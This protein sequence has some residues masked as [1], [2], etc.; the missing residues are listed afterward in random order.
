MRR[1][2]GSGEGWRGRAGVRGVVEMER[3]RSGEGMERV[4]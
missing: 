3:E 2:R 4:W 1:M